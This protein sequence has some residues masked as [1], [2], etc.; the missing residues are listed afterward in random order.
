MGT[1]GKRLPPA[2]EQRQSDLDPRGGGRAGAPAEMQRPR[3]LDR[4]PDVGARAAHGPLD[5]GARARSGG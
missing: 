2:L 3:L 5:A 1:S 4:E